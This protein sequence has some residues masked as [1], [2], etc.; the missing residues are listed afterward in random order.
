MFG[1]FRSRATV[2]PLGRIELGRSA[3]R[4]IEVVQSRTISKSMIRSGMMSHRVWRLPLAA[5][6]NPRKGAFLTAVHLR[7]GSAERH[8]VTA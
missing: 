1:I 5:S 7:Q 4:S 2:E 3:S 8:A 6:S